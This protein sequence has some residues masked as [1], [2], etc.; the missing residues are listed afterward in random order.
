MADPQKSQM[1]A[2]AQQTLG[3]PTGFKTYSPF[4]FSGMNTQSSAIAVDDKEFSYVENFL[5]I[6]DGKLRTAWDV[7]APLYTAS[8]GLTIVAFFA[9]TIGSSYYFVV[10]LSDGSAVQVA[11]PSGSTTSIAAAGTFYQSANGMLPGFSQYGTQFLLISNRNTGNDYWAWDGS[12]LYG[13]GTAAPNQQ[14]NPDILASGLDYASAPTV[15]PFGGSGTGLA[16]TASVS[17]GAVVNLQ[18]INPGSGYQPGDIVQ[19]AF[20]GGGSD[21]SAILTAQLV[22]GQVGAVNVTAG[23]TGYTV[24][25]SVSFSGGGGTG[26]AGTALVS[27]G[28]VIG[29]TITNQGSGYTSA[30]TIAFGGPGTGA[31]ASALLA[32]AGVQSVTVVNAGS[33]FTTNPIIKFVGGGGSGATGQVLLTPTPVVRINV[34]NGGSGYASP[35]AVTL[36]P[37]PS[38][39]SAN[40][41]IDGTGTVTS[42]QVT[43]SGSSVNSAPIVSLAAPPAGGSQATAE[44][45]LTPTSIAS[46]TIANAG[47]GYTNAP[48]VEITPG[49]N[50]AAYATVELMPY[51]ISGSSIE[52]FNSRV[53]ICNPA[54]PLYGSQPP[55]GNFSYSAASSLTDF[56]TSDGGGLFVNSD[57]FLQTQYVAIRQSNGYL[58]FFGDGSVS[59]VSNVITSGTPAT[60]TF[61]YQNVDPQN[62]LS[63]RDSIQDFG[64]SILAGNSTGIYGLYGGNLAK[65]SSKMDDIF[66]NAI[67][68][69]TADAV[70]PSAATA[71][72]FDIKHYL[73]LMTIQ[74]PDTKQYRNAMVTWNE[75]EWIVTSQSVTLTYIGSQKISS[76]FYAW[77]TNGTN[78]YPL[79]NAP[80]T[81]LTKRFDTKQ[82][83]ADSSFLVKDLMFTSMTAQ[84]LSSGAAGVQGS[85]SYVASGLAV[86]AAGYGAVQSGVAQNSLISSINFSSPNP[87]WGTWWAGTVGLS[88]VYAGAR[89]TTNSPDFVLANLVLGYVPVGFIG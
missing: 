42:I 74:D 69:P 33:G 84:D 87:Y 59:V 64:R 29:V 79:F 57:R 72:L 73:C 22:S 16:V 60:T 82:Y 55:G 77:G 26:A 40:S 2:R 81:S 47:S 5:R 17:G 23:G 52:T 71:T 88:F 89:F 28:A 3:L 36:T 18:I 65:V 27:A 37:S 19:L 39:F 8:G 41:F 11:Y 12:I 10:F 7:G 80:S 49:A 48:A 70:L 15:T 51:G 4:P 44:A 13:A 34:T 21:S 75:K 20:S 14:N 32:P 67:F 68:P 1:S 85:M 24:A 78:L 45:V 66:V 9:Y 50:N 25:P 30:P 31:S 58:Y 86:Q 76:K 38:G 62:G 83:G 56:A 61:N 63:W 53:W 54:P 35:P 6:G 43:A 46:V